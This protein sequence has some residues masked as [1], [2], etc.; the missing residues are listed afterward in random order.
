MQELM[1]WLYGKSD[2]NKHI[3]EMAVKAVEL[4]KKTPSMDYQEL[5]KALNIEFNQYQK[6]KRT[7]YFVVNPLKKVQLIQEKRMYE[8]GKKNK[9]KTHYFLTPDR[10]VGYMTAIVEDFHKSVKEN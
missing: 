7:F 5:C 2:R 9:Y 6:P 1:T 4:L 3:R 10:F 8:D